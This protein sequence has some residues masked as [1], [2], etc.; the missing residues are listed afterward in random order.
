DPSAPWKG[1]GWTGTIPG[2]RAVR[3]LLCGVGRYS[4]DAM[5]KKWLTGGRCPPL[6]VSAGFAGALTPGLDIGSLVR[7]AEL[8][9]D[10]AGRVWPVTGIPGT[11]GRVVTHAFMIGRPA[12]KEALGRKWRADAVDMESAAVARLCSEH[13]IPF[14]CVRVISDRLQDRLPP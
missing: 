1:N 13:A 4:A 3:V 5:L 8:V 6:L 14:G 7:P 11:S 10:E 12:D 2:G 9:D